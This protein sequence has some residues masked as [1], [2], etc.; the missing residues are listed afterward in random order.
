MKVGYWSNF[1][2]E[3]SLMARHVAGK[4]KACAFQYI[5][6]TWNVSSKLITFLPLSFN[7]HSFSMNKT[8]FFGLLFCV[9]YN[10]SEPLK[11][12]LNIFFT[13][14]LLIMCLL[15]SYLCIHKW[16]SVWQNYCT[17]VLVGII[18]LSFQVQK[19]SLPTT[20]DVAAYT[21]FQYAFVHRHKV[22]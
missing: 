22:T 16:F 5:Y 6:W 9:S 19:M 4:T 21:W 15:L 2:P 7:C 14:M 13:Y 18:F 1:L 20:P 3:T 17:N 11:V 8:S 12:S 10:F